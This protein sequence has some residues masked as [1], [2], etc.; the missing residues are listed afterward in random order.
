VEEQYT[1]LVAC[2]RRV[3]NSRG[4]EST[5]VARRQDH[6][7]RQLGQILVRGAAVSSYTNAQVMELWNEHDQWPL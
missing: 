6:R 7:T 1:V 3:T 2:E 5:K 4:E